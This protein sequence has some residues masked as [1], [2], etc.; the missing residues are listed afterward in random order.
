MSSECTCIN[1]DPKGTHWPHCEAL[2]LGCELSVDISTAEYGTEIKAWDSCCGPG[3]LFLFATLE[4]VGRFSWVDL[5]L[6]LGC[7]VQWLLNS[8][9]W[10]FCE[11]TYLL[12]AW[13]I[14]DSNSFWRFKMLWIKILRGVE[15]KKRWVLRSSHLCNGN[16][17]HFNTWKTLLVTA[18]GMWELGTAQLIEVSC[19]FSLPSRTSLITSS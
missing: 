9:V 12:I 14:F 4:K 8:L 17:N 18:V 5:C 11:D 6:V 7:V 3:L 19:R 16:N 15:D 2:D 1:C 10:H 13:L